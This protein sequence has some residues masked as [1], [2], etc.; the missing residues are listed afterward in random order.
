MPAGSDSDDDHAEDCHQN[1]ALVIPDIVAPDPPRQ[2]SGRLV[3]P[4]FLSRSFLFCQVSAAPQE[5]ADIY[6]GLRV[7]ANCPFKCLEAIEAEGLAAW[8]PKAI[9]IKFL[10]I[11]FGGKKGVN[12]N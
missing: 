7:A 8:V 3:H 11:A 2:S 10:M 4:Q 5:L 12:V 1:C 6:H 9:Y